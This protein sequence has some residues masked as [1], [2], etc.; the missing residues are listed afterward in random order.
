M[1]KYLRKLLFLF[2][3]LTTLGYGVWVNARWVGEGYAQVH[4]EVSRR[5]PQ[6]ADSRGYL[7]W[8]VAREGCT[9]ALLGRLWREAPRYQARQGIGLSGVGLGLLLFALLSRT[10]SRTVERKHLERGG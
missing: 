3:G 2:L 5:A 10:T 1:E 7:R 8:C 6:F 9:D 4:L